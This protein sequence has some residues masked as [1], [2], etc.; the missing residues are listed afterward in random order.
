MHEGHFTE[1]IVESIIGEL[2]KYPGRKVESVT[3]KVG[4]VYH[5]V[6]D[7]VLMHY[8]LLTKST[9]LEGVTLKLLEEP[10][11]VLCSQCAKQG[12]IEDH[13]LLL[14]SFCHSHQVVTVAGDKVTI[15][16]IVLK[17]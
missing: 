17:P 9:D 14:C 5:L 4:E 11:Q 16:Q 1:Q 2:K 12:P 13:H 7:S 15:E 10:M 8:E 3:V 6:P